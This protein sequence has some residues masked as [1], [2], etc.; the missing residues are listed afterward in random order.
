[1]IRDKCDPCRFGKL[2]TPSFRR[3]PESHFGIEFSDILY[4]RSGAVTCTAD[5]IPAYAGM[6]ACADEERGRP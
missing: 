6:T 4:R 3:R 1:L 5:V 2:S